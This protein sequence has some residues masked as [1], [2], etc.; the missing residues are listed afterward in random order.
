M[1]EMLLDQRQ[2]SANNIVAI[3]H[4]RGDNVTGNRLALRVKK[5]YADAC[6]P[7][8]AREAATGLDLFACI[9]EER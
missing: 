6:L 3:L 4:P 2:Q 8:R 5:L 9:R 1:M 7:R